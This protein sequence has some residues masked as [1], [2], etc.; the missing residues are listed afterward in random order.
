MFAD[1]NKHAV[2]PSRSLGIL[3]DHRDPLAELS[4]HL[5][6]KVPVFN[7]LTEKEKT[8]ISNRSPKLFTL[9]SI[10]QATGALLR[11]KKKQQITDEEQ[12][13]AL[14][15]WNEVANLIPEWTMAKKRKFLVPFSERSIS[16]PMGLRWYL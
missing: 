9:S 8:S 16:I 13:L 10:Y 5:M 15:F 1:L 3:Y 7:G 11:K 6:L 2:R 12:D 14:E 4:R